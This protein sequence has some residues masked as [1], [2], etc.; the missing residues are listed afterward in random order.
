[1]SELKLTNKQKRFIDEY[2]VDINATQA[3][4]RTGYSKR[5][6]AAIG[7]ENLL[8]PAIADEIKR[9]IKE[10]GMPAEEVILR[11]GDMA[12]GDLADLMDVTTSG[13]TIKLMDKDERGNLIVSPKTKLIKK[14]KQKVTTYLSKKEDGEDREII[15]TELELYSAQEALNLLGKHHKLFT[16][17][18]QINVGK[19]I[20]VRLTD[21][22]D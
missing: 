14:I 4:I 10:M 16:D 19:A 12:R 20:K 2:L 21:G 5:S 18:V 11:L 17:N 6:A 7:N 9:R 13:F 22:D 1:M 15:E 3:A 8:K